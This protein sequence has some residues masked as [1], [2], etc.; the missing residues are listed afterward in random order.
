[1]AKLEG[2][3]TWWYLE[4]NGVKWRGKKKTKTRKAADDP[5]ISAQAVEWIH[6]GLQMHASV[7]EPIC[8]CS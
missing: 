4:L 1:M 5:V 8:T 2:T 3:I 6:M 7:I